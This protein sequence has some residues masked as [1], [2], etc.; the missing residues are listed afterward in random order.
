MWSQTVI[1][2]ALITILVVK[3]CRSPKVFVPE[4]IRDSTYRLTQGVLALYTTDFLLLIAF[5]TPITP[6]HES[7]WLGVSCSLF[8][9]AVVILNMICGLS[10][11][12]EKGESGSQ[13]E[14]QLA[15]VFGTGVCIFWLYVEVMGLLLKI[16]P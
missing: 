11:R 3:L 1:L 9:I 12:M 5:H 8:L 10:G 7:G 2:T 4:A 14:Q 13:Q 16:S 15:V 6:L